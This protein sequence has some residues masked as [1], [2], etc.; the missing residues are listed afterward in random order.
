MRNATEAQEALSLALERDEY[1]RVRISDSNGNLVDRT[2]WVQ[3][4]RIYDDV[5]AFAHGC[6]LT[7]HRRIGDDSIAPLMQS[8]S[9]IAGG[10]RVVVEVAFAEIGA[11]APG[12]ADWIKVFDGRVDDPQW[13]GLSND[14]TFSC[15]SRIAALL[16]DRWLESAHIGEYSGLQQVVMQQLMDAVLGEDAPT[17][18]VIGDPATTIPTYNQRRQSL[19]DALQALADVNGWVVRERWHDP[20]GDFR[21]VLYEPDRDQVFPDATFTAADFF[22]HGDVRLQTLG[23][24]TVVE[25]EWQENLFGIAEDPD[26]IAIEGVGRKVLYIDASNDPLI[27]SQAQAQSLAELILRD[28]STALVGQSTSH[29]LFWR[30]QLGDLYEYPADGE[31]AS[32]SRRMAV[33]GYEHTITGDPEIPSTT[34]IDLRGQPSGGAGR[35]YV[36][37]RRT[38]ERRELFP[39]E[40]QDPPEPPILVGDVALYYTEGEGPGFFAESDRESSL[41][42]FISTTR[43]GTGLG[44]LFRAVTQEEADAGITLYVVIGIAN[45]SEGVPWPAVRGWVEQPTAEGVTIEIGADPAGIVALES[46]SAQGATIADDETA[47]SGVSFS[48]PDVVHEGIVIGTLEPETCRLVHVRLVVAEG[49][50]PQITDGRICFATCFPRDASEPES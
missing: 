18:V 20:S 33:V 4:V 31:W 36:R 8:P 37:D 49:A 7:L 35:W 11:D 2:R 27:T 43:I 1:L 47:P 39:E 16:H 5:E 42:G 12:E 38:R 34:R 41:G 50:E 21:L 3:E 15:R 19:A 32:E 9:M 22:E 46:E 10:R 30:V 23:V 40:T 13:G 24:R 44:N 6:D 26:A 48:A 14:L 29:G 28:V 45:T 25:I 17:L